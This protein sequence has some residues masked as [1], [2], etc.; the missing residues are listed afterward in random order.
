M[1]EI[2]SECERKARKLHTCNYCG[3]I[4]QPGETYD[5][6]VLRYAGDMYDWKYA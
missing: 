3:E 1:P 6:A 4:I 2:I 5:Y